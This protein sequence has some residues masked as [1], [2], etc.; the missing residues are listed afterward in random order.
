MPCTVVNGRIDGTRIT[1]WDV[2]LYVVEGC[3][4]EEILDELPLTPSQ[5]QAAMD[6]IRNNREYVAEGHRRI[7]ERNARG[8]PPEIQARI[9]QTQAKMRAWLEQRRKEQ[10]SAGSPR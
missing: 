5:L 6:F 7:E 4:T 8:N 9:V 10:A 3:T 1:V 2:F